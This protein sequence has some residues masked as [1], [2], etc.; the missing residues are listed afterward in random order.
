MMST[1]DATSLRSAEQAVPARAAVRPFAPQVPSIPRT[2]VRLAQYLG[3]GRSYSLVS[4]D[5]TLTIASVLNLTPEL[6]DVLN[7]SGP[8]GS[9]AIAEGA[10][11]LRALGDIDLANETGADA[12]RWQWLQSAVLG[13]LG[14][15]PFS[16]ADRLS[17]DA[18][19]TSRDQVV[20][21]IELRG[22]QHSIT[23]HAAAPAKV[24][25]DFL[26]RGDWTAARLPA[27]RFAG[28]PLTAAVRVA[29]HT[30][31]LNH[32]RTLAAGDII[33]PDT[34]LFDC[35]GA[36]SV[37]LG[38]LTAHVR[39]KAPSALTILYMEGSM[40]QDNK[41]DDPYDDFDDSVYDEGSDEYGSEDDEDDNVDD[42][43]DAD[44]YDDADGEEYLDDEDGEEDVG[45]D[46]AR[47]SEALSEF[48]DDDTGGLSRSEDEA[49]GADHDAP[50]S[51]PVV[52]VEKRSAAASQK[53][54]APAAK[55]AGTRR[56]VDLD[57]TPVTLSFELGRVRLTL[58]ELRALD[59]GSVLDL[60]GGSPQAIAIVASG[61]RLGTG[62]L[63]DID[64]QLGIRI[65]DWNA[66]P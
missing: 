55:E 13:R 11:L 63:V 36:G 27:D 44:D 56:P 38:A 21:R 41:N 1:A 20:L 4:R 33:V 24:W 14:D 25:L 40:A 7:M 66:A 39:F 5:A 52:P 61:R 18:L 31:T 48:D 23:T 29:C 30:L 8:F 19:R 22:A 65:T 46:E 15:T 17:R 34:P 62:E 58:G 57:K 6:S 35:A 42:V 47:Q 2:Q 60:T 43:D 45:G 28:L 3:R 59:A 64:G 37:G 51:A 49:F 53:Q 54:A 9:I 10:R 16:R 32:A 12:S 26:Q 50:A